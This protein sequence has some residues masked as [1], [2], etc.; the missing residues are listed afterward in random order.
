[1]L[2]FLHSSRD[3]GP[4]DLL[5]QRA[6][7]VVLIALH[8]RRGVPSSVAMVAPRGA[9]WPLFTRNSF[10]RNWGEASVLGGSMSSPLFWH[11]LL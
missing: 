3:L 9:S 5:R 10:L 6:A 11:L 4:Y 1:M 2:E 7:K 8:E